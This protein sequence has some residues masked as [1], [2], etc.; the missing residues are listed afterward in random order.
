MNAVVSQKVTE[1]RVSR[2]VHG[3]WILRHHYANLSKHRNMP[4]THGHHA[5][6]YGVD[7]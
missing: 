6:A 1:S 7:L 2:Y 5:S 3:A 4:D